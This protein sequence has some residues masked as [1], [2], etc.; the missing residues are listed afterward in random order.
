MVLCQLCKENEATQK[1]H[2][3]YFPNLVIDICIECH[4]LI[5]KH[6]VGLGKNSEEY[7]IKDAP[8]DIVI[9]FLSADLRLVFNCLACGETYYTSFRLIDLLILRRNIKEPN[10]K[11]SVCKKKAGYALDAEKSFITT[12]Y[13]SFYIEFKEVSP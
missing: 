5:H 13:D 9:P 11:C 3:S 2:I 7:I 8:S 6:G 4:K 1:H 10:R 12:E